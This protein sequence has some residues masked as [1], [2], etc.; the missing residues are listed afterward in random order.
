MASRI[1]LSLWLT[2]YAVT[3]TSL[4]VSPTESEKSMITPGPKWDD[5]KKRYV[6]YVYYYVD[7]EYTTTCGYI[8]HDIGECYLGF[9]K[10]LADMLIISSCSEWSLWDK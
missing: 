3:V 7:Y 5:L 6:Y 8:S 4:A 9:P 1:I 10:S 2:L